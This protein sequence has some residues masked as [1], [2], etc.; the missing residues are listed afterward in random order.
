M[1]RPPHCP[2]NPEC[3]LDLS[4]FQNTCN[5]CHELN[6]DANAE[7]GV[8]KPGLFGTDS[9]YANDAVSHTLKIPHLRN[10]Y[11]KVGMFGSVRA[12]ADAA[13]SARL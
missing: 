10:I 6:P 7:F 12:A 4:D 9:K 5:G 11:Q 1:P 3:S 13:R 2:P 8:S